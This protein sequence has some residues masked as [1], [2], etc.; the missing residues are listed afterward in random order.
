MNEKVCV[1]VCEYVFVCVCHTPQTRTDLPHS[2]LGR[3][4]LQSDSFISREAVE[5][6][7]CGRDKCPQALL[8]LFLHE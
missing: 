1:Y 8:F 6:R 5:S 7:V 4:V 2:I 3:M